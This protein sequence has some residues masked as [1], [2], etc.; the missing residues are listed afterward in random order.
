VSGGP[1]GAAS[2]KLAIPVGGDE[3]VFEHFVS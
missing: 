2:R 3:N 1:A